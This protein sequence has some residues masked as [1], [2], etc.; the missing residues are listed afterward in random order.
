M[1]RKTEEI[2][3]RQ[4]P[5]NQGYNKGESLDFSEVNAILGEYP[6]NGTLEEQKDVIHRAITSACAILDD[7]SNTTIPS[8][9]STTKIDFL[10]N[11][12]QQLVAAIVDALLS[13]KVIMLLMVYKTLMEPEDSEGKDM[14]NTEDLLR[15][16]NNLIKSVVREV[17][18]L[19]IQKLM[20]YIIEHLT[21]LALQL[22]ARVLSELFAA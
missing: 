8:D 13:P 1:L 4:M 11:I 17:R 3:Y 14:F 21:P 6:V 9:R 15:L 5:Y 22:Q 12:L 20:D 18:E 7:S 16:M 19:I 2:R 10:T